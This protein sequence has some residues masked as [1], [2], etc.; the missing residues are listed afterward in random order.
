MVNDEA[1]SDLQ[2]K[3]RDYAAASLSRSDLAALPSEQFDLWLTAALNLNL[4]DATA[5]AIATVDPDGC[6]AVRVVLLKDRSQ[7]DYTFF[8]DQRSRKGQ[9]LQRNPR[10]EMLFY[11]RE[12]ERQVRINGLVEPVATEVSEQYFASRPRDSQISAAASQQSA[13]IADRAALERQAMNVNVQFPGQVP[14][15]TGWGGYVLRADRY[16]FWQGR[17]GRLHDRFEYRRKDAEQWEI[18]RLQP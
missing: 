15:P 10:A 14:L 12:L 7:D 13:P 9:H 1:T 3:R 17:V 8:T 5:C 11:W 6:P 16:E 2:G 4:V 18:T